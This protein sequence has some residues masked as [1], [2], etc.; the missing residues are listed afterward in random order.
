MDFSDFMRVMTGPQNPIHGRDGQIIITKKY[1]SQLILEDYFLLKSTSW[2]Y[3]IFFFFFNCTT[4]CC[5]TSILFFILFYFCVYSMWGNKEKLMLIVDWALFICLNIPFYIIFKPSS[6]T[7]KCVESYSEFQCF[8][9][10]F[11]LFN[12]TYK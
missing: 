1:F 4:F 8:P 11:S 6:I 12:K 2:E 3:K 9:E 7:N 10:Q 5:K